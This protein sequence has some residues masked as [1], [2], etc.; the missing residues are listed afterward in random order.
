MKEKI[1]PFVICFILTIP[2]LSQNRDKKLSDLHLPETY[3]TVT[4]ESQA[5]IEKL[6]KTFSIDK[7]FY[8]AENSNFTVQIW[9]NQNQYLRFDSL[10]IPYS[11][12]ENEANKSALSMA[13]S[14]VEMQSWNHYPTYSTY[15]AMMDR[16]QSRYPQ[17]CRID[18]ILSNTPGGHKI[19]AAHISNHPELEENKPAFFYSSSIHGDEVS[20]YILMLRLIDYLLSNY[21]KDSSIQNLVNNIKIWICPLENPDGTYRVSNNLIGP[22]PISTRGNA[23]GMDLNRSYPPIGYLRHPLEPEI[24]AMIHFVESHYFVMSANF[25]GGS[26]VYNYP[27]DLW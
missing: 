3:V 22:S 8:H 20:G 13:T 23:N 10:D 27:F 9:L 2:L 26:E 17:L 18:T 11:T 1:L 5:Q 12:I 7:V 25:H 16:F 19:L 24:E 6:G 14:V 21:E 15:L 4:L